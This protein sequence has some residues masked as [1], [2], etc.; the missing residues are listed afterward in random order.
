MCVYVCVYIYI[1]ICIYL[2]IHVYIYIYI[3]IDA[4][5][6]LHVSFDH[7]RY[8]CVRLFVLFYISDYVLCALI[9]VSAVGRTTVYV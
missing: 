6:L 5:V 9:V 2:C 7:V 4:H 1:Y 8:Y 3:D